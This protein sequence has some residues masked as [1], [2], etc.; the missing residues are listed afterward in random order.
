MLSFFDKSK[1][2]LL[3]IIAWI[4]SDSSFPVQ[5]VQSYN[6]GEFVSVSSVFTELVARNTFYTKFSPLSNNSFERYNRTTPT[7]ERSLIIFG[8]TL[9][10]FWG[11][12]VKKTCVLYSFKPSIIKKKSPPH[13][14]LCGLR[15]WT[16]KHKLWLTSPGGYSAELSKVKF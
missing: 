5:W 16:Y 4:E 6:G 1:N 12:A 7:K 15:P 14:I 2:A 10:K 3:D 13:E 9:S 11:G 8:N